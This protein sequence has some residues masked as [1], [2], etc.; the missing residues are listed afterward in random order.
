MVE[1]PEAA[2]LPDSPETVQMKVDTIRSQFEEY[3]PNYNE[4][5]F[6]RGNM[7]QTLLNAEQQLAIQRADK[8]MTEETADALEQSVANLEYPHAAAKERQ[9]QYAQEQ[10]KIN[11]RITELSDK[12]KAVPHDTDAEYDERLGLMTRLS[13]I[14]IAVRNYGLAAQAFPEVARPQKPE[15]VKSKLNWHTEGELPN[16]EDEAEVEV[17]DVSEQPPIETEEADDG[18][19]EPIVTKAQSYKE[20]DN[21]TPENMSEVIKAQQEAYAKLLEVLENEGFNTE[22]ATTTDLINLANIRYFDARY[23]ENQASSNNRQNE[24]IAI[25]AEIK[26]FALALRLLEARRDLEELVPKYVPAKKTE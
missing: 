10:T 6:N 7:L 20:I 12:I 24:K 21:V 3:G 9:E 26:T 13:K 15:P 25:T 1:T 18:N 17:T 11:T 5:D 14:K 22:T 19:E 16:T 23:R 4:Q 2:E 8:E